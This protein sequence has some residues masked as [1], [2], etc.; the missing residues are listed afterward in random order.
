VSAND[1]SGNLLDTRGI[2]CLLIMFSS[3]WCWKVHIMKYQWI[4]LHRIYD[5][6]HNKKKLKHVCTYIHIH[7]HTQKKKDT[8]TC[9][10]LCNPYYCL[11]CTCPSRC[12][13]HAL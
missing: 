10:V 3:S 4:I 5:P 1:F 9:V 11:S 7:T 13:C 6:K 12:K 8:H 2:L